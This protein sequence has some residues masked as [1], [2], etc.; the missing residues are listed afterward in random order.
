MSERRL[1][2]A[3]LGVVLLA[4]L[5]AAAGAG[6][7]EA[8]RVPVRWELLSVDEDLRTLRIA[9]LTGGCMGNDGVARV[10]ETRRRITIGVDVHAATDEAC[11]TDLRF[12]SLRVTLRRAVAGRRIAGGPP[13]GPGLLWRTPPRA[14]GLLDLAAADAATALRVQGLKVRL[15]GRRRGT[16]AF[17]SPMPG[18]LVRGGTVRLTVGRGLFRVRAARACLRG[19]GLS[20]V[21]LVPAPGDADAP[22]VEIQARDGDT[23]VLAGLYADPHRARERAR[24][25]RRNARAFDGVVERA[26]RVTIVWTKPPAP[27]LRATVRGCVTGRYAP[28][29]V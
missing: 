8:P 23:N 6:G 2:G 26:H 16:V 15:I 18:R 29:R 21:A 25:I 1:T 20:A 3:V 22:D 17:Q 10:R 9:Y 5:P 24:E 12:R 7:A 14:P 11:T 4:L 13:V 27:A 19:A 28:R